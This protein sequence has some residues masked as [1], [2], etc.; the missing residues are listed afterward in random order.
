MYYDDAKGLLQV[1]ISGYEWK[2]HVRYRCV[3]FDADGRSIQTR[4][5]EITQS[6]VSAPLT[7]T[8]QQSTVEAGNGD[9]IS[10][11]VTVSGGKEPY[12][13]QWKRAEIGENNRIYPYSNL[14]SSDHYG[15]T[16]SELNIWVGSTSYMYWCLVKDAE[17]STAEA[18]F[19]LKIKPRRAMPNRFG[20]G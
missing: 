2:D 1:K 12:T 20:S 15:E 16:T 19:T 3:V 8:T 17:G 18:F 11:Q 14:S 9:Q 13:Y 10:F 7:V 4:P 6:V 5:V